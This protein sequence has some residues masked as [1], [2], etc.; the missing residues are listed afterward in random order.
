MPHLDRLACERGRFH[1]CRFRLHVRIHE[2]ALALGAE[3]G[4]GD[5][6]EE[7]AEEVGVVVVHLTDT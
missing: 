3:I 6:V 7:L 4:G 2:P 1:L 5:P